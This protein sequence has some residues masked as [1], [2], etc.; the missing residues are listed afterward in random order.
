MRYFYKKQAMGISRPELSS[1]FTDIGKK[2][3]ETPEAQNAKLTN[4]E[5]QAIKNKKTTIFKLA[6]ERN[7]LANTAKINL[8]EQRKHLS[9]KEEIEFNNKINQIES[10]RL[11]KELIDEIQLKSKEKQENTEKNKLPL[12]ANDPQL[13]KLQ[14][15]VDQLARDNQKIIGPRWQEYSNWFARERQINSNKGLAYFKKEF[16]RF[17]GKNS[18]DKNGLYPRKE[19]Y[20]LLNKYCREAGIA[21]A[22][23]TAIKNHGLQKRLE[24]IKNLRTLKDKLTKSKDLG[25]YSP[26]MKIEIQKELLLKENPNDQEKHLNTLTKVLAKESEGYTLLTGQS[27]KV[28]PYKMKKMG[29]KSIKYFIEN[30]QKIPLNKRLENLSQWKEWIDDEANLGKELAEIFKDDPKKLK[31]ILA[32]FEPEDFIGRTQII[33]E[34]KTQKERNESEIEKEKR[35]LKGSCIA[36]IEKAKHDKILSKKTSNRYIKD[37]INNENNFIND[38]SKQAGDIEK[39]RIFHEKLNNNSAEKIKLEKGYAQNIAAYKEQKET[40]KLDYKNLEDTNYTKKNKSLEKQLNKWKEEFEKEGWKGREKIHEKLKEEIKNKKKEQVNSKEA[41][42]IDTK[43]ENESKKSPEF[44][45]VENEVMDFF[46]NNQYA[47]A[48]HELTKYNLK[49]P[50]DPKILFY[51]KMAIEGMEKFGSGKI[52]TKEEDEKKLEATLE[53]EMISNKNKKEIEKSQLKTLNIKGSKQHEDRHESTNVQERSKTDLLSKVE[54]GSTEESLINDF[55]IKEKATTD[56]NKYTLDQ[57]GSAKKL[58]KIKFAKQGTES[59]ADMNDQEMQALRKETYKQQ[60]KITTEKSG[61]AREIKD[62]SGRTLSAETAEKKLKQEQENFAER[63]AMNAIKRQKKE[64]G[65]RFNKIAE[66]AAAK[67]IA[68]QKLQEKTNKQLERE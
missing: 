38:S 10:P 35:L 68:M 14:E 62:E 44:N 17:E 5:F 18:R 45:K 21:P 66:A 36:T 59:S 41:T 54:A 43:E 1:E 12:E 29:Y 11:M 63:L 22:D 67:R 61:F 57:D 6:E 60:S 4:E 40:F 65:M 16:D 39:L 58:E 20:K 8:H 25:F 56:T 34:E 47:E 53:K 31:L 27:I 33:Q 7:Q 37:V 24:L 52:N 28:G 64:P 46:K 26:K 55:Y 15:K 30:Y 9:P 48:L 19:A 32:K 42:K 13:L 23:S 50:N 51:M 49:T 2:T 3:S